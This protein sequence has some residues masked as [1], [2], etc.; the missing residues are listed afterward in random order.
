MGQYKGAKSVMKMEQSAL[1]VV[2]KPIGTE[3]NAKIVLWYSM[4]AKSVI[5]K[6]LN[7]LFAKVTIF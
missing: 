7:V 6:E 5:M 2:Q 3:A 4:I 1:F